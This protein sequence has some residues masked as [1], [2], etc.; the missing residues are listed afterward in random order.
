MIEYTDSSDVS[1]QWVKHFKKDVNS[2]CGLYVFDQ[3]LPEDTVFPAVR[4]E[5]SARPPMPLEIAFPSLQSLEITKPDL[6]SNEMRKKKGKSKYPSTQTS[7]KKRVKKAGK[8]K[9]H[10]KKKKPTT[11]GR[12]IK[13]KKR[14]ES[15]L[16]A[17]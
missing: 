2:E 13:K 8:R 4:A 15:V 1:S 6:S 14:K 17:W 3:G 12:V 11:G 9:Q 10:T 7:K 16:S 5:T